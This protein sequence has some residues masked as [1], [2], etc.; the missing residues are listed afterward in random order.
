MCLFLKSCAWLFATDPWEAFLVV[1]W[2][3]QLLIWHLAVK[4]WA[5]TSNRR[6]K[7]LLDTGGQLA[8][9]N[10]GL[11]RKVQN[12]LQPLGDRHSRPAMIFLPLWCLL[13]F[14]SSFVFQATRHTLWIAG[15]HAFIFPHLHFS[16]IWICSLSLSPTH[17]LSH[18]EAELWGHSDSIKLKTYFLK[19]LIHF[20]LPAFIK[21]HSQILSCCVFLLKGW[22]ETVP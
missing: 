8:M 18:C 12:F 3:L 15:I 6:A 20:S 5:C 21:L 4:S 17:T 7:Q 19:L 22:R 14:L 1:Y 9:A 16:E 13:S 11:G 2:S 10:L